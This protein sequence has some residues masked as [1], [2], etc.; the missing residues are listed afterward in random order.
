ML[1][2]AAM[3][4]MTLRRVHIST[5][6]VNSMAPAQ[7]AYAGSS[8][9]TRLIGR[10]SVVSPFE[11]SAQEL[12]FDSNCTKNPFGHRDANGNFLAPPQ[13]AT[14]LGQDVIY[15]LHGMWITLD[16]AFGTR[17][18]AIRLMDGNGV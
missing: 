10:H 2:D 3:L 1:P 4:F 6:G 9:R 7:A 18:L 14:A 11:A 8:R 17:P 5:T 13:R 16:S 15:G 12:A